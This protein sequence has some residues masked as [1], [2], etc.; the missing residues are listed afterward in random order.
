MAS[1]NLE[2]VRTAAADRPKAARPLLKSSSVTLDSFKSL[3]AWIAFAG[4]V[5]VVAVLYWAQA[6]IV[7]VCLAILITFVLAPPVAWLQRRVGRVVAVLTVVTLVFTGLGLAGYGVYRQ[8]SMMGDAL[9]TYRTNIRAKM[10]DLRGAKS[11]GSVEKLTK[12]LEQIQGDLGTPKPAPGSV[13]QPVVVSS[14]QVAGFSTIAWLGPIVEPLSTAGFVVTL[15]LFMLLEREDLRG[16]LVGIFGHGHLAV[17]TRAIEEAGARVSRQL[18]LQTVV[19]LIYGAIAC[20]GLLALGVPFPLFWGALG[21]ALR[22]IPYLGPITAAGGPILMA[23]AAL[24]GWTRPLEVSAL[25]MALELFTNFV[26]ETVLYAGAA[27]VSQVALL[28]AIAFWTWLWGPLGLVLATPLTVCV[29]VMGKHV[30]GLEFLGKLMSD[31]PALT[32]EAEYY[33]RL[34]AGDQAEASDLI[35]RYTRTESATNV[36]DAMLIP[37]LNY[38]ERDRLEDRLSP[39]EEAAVV[40]T[41]R[42]LLDMLA[43]SPPPPATGSMRVFAYGINGEP[44][45]L[46]LRMLQQQL[47]DLPITLDIADSR[48]LASELVAH[49]QREGYQTVCFAA[50]PPSP[51]SKLR[52]LVKKVRRALPG[53][54]IM[55]GRWASDEFVD[56]NAQSL[57]EAGASHV[58]A[59]FVGSREYLV[60]AVE[61]LSA[62]AT[63]TPDAA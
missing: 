9:P 15:V 6:V 2:R 47:R 43:D 25:Y 10:L 20:G 29:V 32:V 16:R 36:Y 7:P 3:G 24:P 1:V 45:R 44:D 13:T 22:F 23:V 50:L 56:E 8:M 46:A 17:T 59:K 4:C 19:N 27:G 37:A 41:T 30:P 51:P 63:V 12:T 5:L 49:I 52:L 57:I 39:E 61:G 42:E 21:A 11:T 31:M 58:A 54:R 60:E 14:E 55:V 26:L 48:M 62:P 18:L 28:V 34:L 40:D 38:A 33:Q 35:D 53:A